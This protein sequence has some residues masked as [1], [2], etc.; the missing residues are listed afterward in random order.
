M[1]ITMYDEISLIQPNMPIIFLI[2]F[3]VLVVVNNNRTYI[4]IGSNQYYTYLLA[5]LCHDIQ[6]FSN[7]PSNLDNDFIF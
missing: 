7:A 2:K 1:N 4:F 5:D 3:L 6:L